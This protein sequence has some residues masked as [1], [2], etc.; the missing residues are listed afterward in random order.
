LIVSDVRHTINPTS[1]ERHRVASKPT[2]KQIRVIELFAG[3]GGF[4][5]GLEGR[6]TKEGPK[7]D[8]PFRIVWA[9]QWEPPGSPGRQFA[10]RCYEKRFGPNTR[11]GLPPENEDISVINERLADGTYKMPK[12]DMLVGGFPCQDYSVAKPL[13]QAEGIEGKKGVLWWEIYERL[14]Q[15]KPRYV[16]L[17][18]VDRLLKSPATQRGRDFAVILACLAQLGYL[19]EWRVI[20]AADYG[21]AQRRRRV[22]V[23]AEKLVPSQATKIHLEDRLLDSGVMARA[24]RVEERASFL[25]DPSSVRPA[26]FA[27]HHDLDLVRDSHF[28]YF[29]SEEYG[30]SSHARSFLGA[31]VMVE[32]QGIQLSVRPVPREANKKTL[33]HVTQSTKSIPSEYFIH[34]D[35]HSRWEY[36]KGSKREKRVSKTGFEYY[37]AEG[38]MTCPDALD[39]PSRTILTGEGGTGPSRFKHAVLHPDGRLRRLM[40]EE[41]EAL[42]G[43]P[44]R[45]TDTGMSDAQRAFCMGNALVVDMVKRIGKALI[46]S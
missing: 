20:N 18:N 21:A 9:N 44:R 15:D 28:P 7:T 31:G 38:A 16:V 36:L 23:F 43:F 19:V 30:S 26:Y 5:L 17:E 12:Y 32:G 42:N 33:A 39:R 46:D 14:R 10:Y 24:F 6:P 40:P 22:F 25:K 13:P 8:S 3:V 4:R 37:Y 1:R 2:S 11:P 27:L 35:Q 45:W 41:L 29:V 34:P